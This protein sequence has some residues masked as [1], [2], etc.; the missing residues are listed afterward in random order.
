MNALRATLRNCIDRGPGSQNRENHPDFEAHLRGLVVWASSGSPRRH[1]KLTEL[2]DKIPW[3]S[4]T[5]KLPL[6]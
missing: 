5:P 6:P 1:E 2:F 3:E 4:A